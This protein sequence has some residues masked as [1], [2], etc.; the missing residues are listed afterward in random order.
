MAE[1]RPA[2]A[3]VFR[4]LSEPSTRARIRTIIIPNLNEF[5][6]WPHH[7]PIAAAASAR[8]LPYL[9]W[10]PLRARALN[11]SLITEES[12]YIMIADSGE[13]AARREGL[14]WGEIASGARQQT[15]I[16]V[17]IGVENG[18]PLEMVGPTRVD[19]ALDEATQL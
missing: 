19:M 10:V 3:S 11:F 18:A 1:I 7:D 6:P 4:A 8:W 5:H 2:P 15:E 14:E 17:M 9:R 16:P 12:R 13:L